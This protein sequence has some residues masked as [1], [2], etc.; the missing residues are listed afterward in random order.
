MSREEEAF[1]DALLSEMGA[2]YPPTKP[3][4]PPA[5]KHV[6]DIHGTPKKKSRVTYK[7]PLKDTKDLL[8]GAEDWD[9]DDG[10]DDDEAGASD[11][12]V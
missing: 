12:A 8:N 11:T 10:L 4:L 6:N 5:L 3:P 9:W 1:L 7:S 2:S